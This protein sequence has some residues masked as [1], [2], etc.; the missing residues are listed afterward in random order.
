MRSSRSPSRR[1]WKA[2]AAGRARMGSRVAITSATPGP[3]ALVVPAFLYRLAGENMR[4]VP[5]D[6]DDRLGRV[7]QVGR[8]VRRAFQ[9][10]AL[11]VDVGRAG[12]L[13]RQPG[14]GRQLGRRQD[15]QLD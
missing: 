5:K 12:D 7:A 8:R 15:A 2:R 4:S 13:A 3:R 10:I 14:E 1:V 11:G 6:A 9:P